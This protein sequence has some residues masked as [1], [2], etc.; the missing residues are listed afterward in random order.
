MLEF[1]K[2]D[3]PDIFCIQETKARPEQLDPVILDFEGFEKYFTSAE[4]KG[5]SGVST[6]SRDEPLEVEYGLGIESLDREGRLVISHHEKFILFNAYFP[7]GKQ[8]DERLRFKLDFYEA[9]LERILEYR[10]SRAVVFCGDVNTA[11]NEIDLARP[12]ENEKISGFLPIERK[13]IDKVI[14]SGFF[15]SFRHTHP[16]EVSYS[17]WDYKTR[18]RERDIGWRID[19]F[20]L[21][22]V[23]LPKL[24]DAFILK[25]VTGSDH[26][27]VG[28]ELDV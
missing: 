3:G 5:Y 28:I 6:W 18:A 7:N 8:G 1:I 2:E 11:H 23:L 17:W 19:Y 24:N 9:F 21:D 14:G 4:K 26:C 16:E 10:K 13:W 27:P 25:E 22:E 15:D 20:F 12:K